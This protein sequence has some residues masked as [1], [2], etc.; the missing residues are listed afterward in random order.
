MTT[1]EEPMDVRRLDE[2]ERRVSALEFDMLPH[3]RLGP[4]PESH[5]PDP[6]VVKSLVEVARRAL[7]KEQ[8]MVRAKF[9]CQEI[10]HTHY[11]TATTIILRPQYDQSIEED[12]R[13]AKATPSGEV[14][15]F[16][17]N[18]PAQAFFELG[19]SYYLDFSKAE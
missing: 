3:R 9:M 1:S 14:T 11:G 12:K 15:M 4:R 7:Q 17:D 8:Q 19:K 13:F 16:V 5:T 10:R 6:E 2:L 18:P